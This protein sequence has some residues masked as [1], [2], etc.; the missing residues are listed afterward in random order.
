M[1]VKKMLNAIRNNG[2]E[3]FNKNIPIIKSN[4]EKLP[5]IQIIDEY[6]NGVKCTILILSRDTTILENATIFRGLI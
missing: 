1:N 6:P 3:D 4:L 2:L 5:D